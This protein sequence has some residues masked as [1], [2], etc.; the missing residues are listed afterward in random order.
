MFVEVMRDR[1]G[2]GGGAADEGTARIF[3]FVVA[4]VNPVVAALRAIRRGLLLEFLNLLLQLLKL[5]PARGKLALRG[6]LRLCRADQLGA[7][8]R[9]DSV[10]VAV[11]A[12]TTR[13]GGAVA[14]VHFEQRL[15]QLGN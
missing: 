1:G 6:A 5:A 11:A 10:V 2:S 13:V 3:A 8:L 4:V 12:T 9:A 15:L 7:Q 14:A